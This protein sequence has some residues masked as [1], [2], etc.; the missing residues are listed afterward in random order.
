MYHGN[1]KASIIDSDFIAGFDW[2][3][4]LITLV[5]A[6]AGKLVGCGVAGIATRLPLREAAA[7][8]VT[9]NARGAMEI[10]LGAIALQNGVIAT[11]LFVALV[12]MA[13]VT[14]AAVGPGLRLLGVRP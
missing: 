10:I 12:V 14:S 11:D 8:G 1:I 3:L 5:V 9:M 6:S 13:V 4:V 7:I 2:R